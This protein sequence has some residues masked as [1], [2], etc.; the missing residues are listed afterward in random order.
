VKPFLRDLW[1]FILDGGWIFAVG[2]TLL[3]AALVLDL[4]GV[5]AP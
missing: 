2:Y 1:Q 5:P 4:M 3:I